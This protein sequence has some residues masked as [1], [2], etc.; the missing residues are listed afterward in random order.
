MKRLFAGAVLAATIAMT[1]AL[2]ASPPP[3][4]WSGFYINLGYGYGLWAADTT[5][6]NSTTGNCALC[7][8]VRQ[9]GNGWLA[10][11]G[12][13]YDRQ[14]GNIVGGVFGDFDFA[15][16][17]GSLQDQGPVSVAET[18]LDRAWSIG[19]RVGWLPTAGAMTFVSG[20]FTQAHFTGNTLLAANGLPFSPTIS[21]QSSTTPGWFVGGGVET[22]MMPGWFWRTE[23]RWAHYDQKDILSC[24][25]TSGLCGTGPSFSS[26]R[27]DPWVQTIRSQ[28]IYKF[29]SG[30]SA[31]PLTGIGSMFTEAFAPAPARSDWN[32]L[33]V[34]GGIGYG[35]WAADTTT[36]NPVT[37]V[38]ANCVASTQGGRGGLGTVGGG[39]DRQVTAKIVAGV[40]GDVDFASLKGSLE[41]GGPVA[42]A[43]TKMN[44][45]WS[46]G[47][48]I[49]Y[50][51][52]P[53]V[54]SYLNFGYSQAHFTGEGASPNP[55]TGTFIAGSRSYQAFNTSG[56]FIGGGE[57]IM[58]SPG[59]FWRNEYRVTN[60]DTRDIQACTTATGVCGVGGPGNS[61]RFADPVV[62][63]FRSEVIYKFNW[64]G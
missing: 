29:G 23:Y 52:T 13:G 64:G 63:T 18:K 55:P 38:C 11:V 49:G 37:G 22:S 57:E 60:F 44:R 45:S 35:F 34:M 26:V 48:R 31:N 42:F 5:T 58:F 12:L 53:T 6:V 19:A 1:P 51:V 43:E 8:P 40:F 39:Y 16:I 10:T 9:G 4:D 54:L 30:G 41:D 21:Y 2:A 3:M 17:K 15:S 59:W 36:I 56:Y 61:I 32:G 24:N 27:F 33:Y 47:G 7:G 28:I 62:Q 20:G 46:V 50:L 14:F 25:D